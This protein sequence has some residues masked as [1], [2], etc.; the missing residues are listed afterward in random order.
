MA[1]RFG[2]SVAEAGLGDLLA[3]VAYKSKTCGRNLIKVDSRYTTQICGVC[4]ALTGPKGL[5]G[6]S[7]RFWD[8]PCGGHLDRDIN[9]AENIL[10]SGVDSASNNGGRKHVAA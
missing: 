3:K 4:G 6:L 5:R 9:A 8:C 2:K 10:K 1:K 7:E